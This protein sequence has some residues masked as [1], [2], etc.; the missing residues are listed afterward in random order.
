MKPA[1]TLA[2]A[3]MAALFC[4]VASSADWVPLVSAA[5]QDRYYYDR[6]KLTIKDDEITYWK[7]VEFASPQSFNGREVA[8]GLLR[9]RLN[10]AEHTARLVSYLYYAPGGETVEYVANHEAEAAPIIPDSVGDAFE[11]RLCP[12]VWQKQEE[13]RIKAEQKAVQ[14]ELSALRKGEAVP[15]PAAPGQPAA[16]TP[17]A[18]SKPEAPA[19]PAVARQAP[20]PPPQ[21]KEQ[22]Y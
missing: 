8:S 11:S 17:P 10:C 3:L 7:K 6:S 9:E 15:P 22:L 13:N 5:T 20:L 19:E 14:A 2:T 12:L 4:T 1:L 16:P 18:S 21:V